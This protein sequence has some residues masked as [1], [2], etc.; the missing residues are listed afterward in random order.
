LLDAEFRHVGEPQ[1]KIHSWSLLS[2]VMALRTSFA[3]LRNAIASTMMGLS[4]E[5]LRS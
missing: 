5:L 1:S 4:T 3:G 2:P